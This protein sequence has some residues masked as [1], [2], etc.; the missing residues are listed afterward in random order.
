[1][2][3]YDQAIV[4]TLLHDNQRFQELYNQHHKLKEKVKDAEIGVLPLDGV[5]L[6]TMKRE[7]LLAKDKMAAMIEEYRRE[8]A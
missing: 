7:K 5:T 1:M 6:G 8:H 3:E 4:D 2:F